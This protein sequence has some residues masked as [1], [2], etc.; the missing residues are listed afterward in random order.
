M[1]VRQ[2]SEK[3]G[4]QNESVAGVSA[5]IR[6][7]IDV[8]HTSIENFNS[9][10]DAHEKQSDVIRN[11]VKINEEIAESIRQENTEF[12]SINEMVEHNTKDIGQ[13]TEQVAALNRMAEQITLLLAQE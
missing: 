6:D 9:M 8:L 4:R 10:G 13:M 11:T 5:G 7:M 12:C 3:L 1:L 2:N